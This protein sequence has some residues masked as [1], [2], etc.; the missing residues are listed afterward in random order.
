MSLIERNRKKDIRRLGAPI[1]NERIVRR[2]LKAGV[3]EVY[4][5]ETVPRRC[6]CDH[7]TARRDQRCQ[8]IHEYNMP[9]VIGAELGLESVCCFAKGRCHHARIRNDDV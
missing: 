7:S 4:V 5:R 9:Q 1:C 2:T 3:F 8:A 6:Q